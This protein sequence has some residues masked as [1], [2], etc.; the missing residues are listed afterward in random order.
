MATDPRTIFAEPL[1][2]MFGDAGNY[3]FLQTKNDNR[4]TEKVLYSP[5]WCYQCVFERI[6]SL[7]K[8]IIINNDNNVLLANKGVQCALCIHTVRVNR[9][10]TV[11]KRKK[12][13]KNLLFRSSWIG[14]KNK[15]KYLQ[16]NS[17]NL[18]LNS[19]YGARKREKEKNIL[20]AASV[21][22]TENAQNKSGNHKSRIYA[23]N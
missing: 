1:K 20:I 6:Y 3:D 2:I 10:Y 13:V 14:E 9:D 7:G 11:D 16:H 12:I 17:N 5:F 19:I 22:H 23:N 15:N 4:R 18:L 21:N 8:T